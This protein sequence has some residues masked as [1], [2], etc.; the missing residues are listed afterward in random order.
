MAQIDPSSSMESF[1]LLRTHLEMCGIV[2]PKTPK[3]HPFN[4]KNLTVIILDSTSVYLYVNLIRSANTFEE[5]TVVIYN[6]ASACFCTTVFTFI[7]WKT[8]E[9]FQF[10]GNLDNV[11]S[12]S[13]FN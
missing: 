1:K 4:A 11:I 10:I 2:L 13:E 9:L 8:S 5:Y 6:T 12:S 7:T 3:M